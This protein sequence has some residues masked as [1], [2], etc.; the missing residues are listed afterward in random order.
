LKTFAQLRSTP[1]NGDVLSDSGWRPLAG[2][3]P[4][5]CCAGKVGFGNRVALDL[6][7]DS[8]LYTR[9]VSALR[10]S[11]LAGRTGVGPDTIRYYEKEG[12]IPEP[13][14]SA[15]GYREYDESVVERME[16]IR[17]AQAAGLRLADI[18]ILLEIKDRGQCPC[19]HTKTIID[20]RLKEISAEMTRLRQLKKRL[21]QLVQDDAACSSPD[22]W[23]CEERFI[24]AGKEARK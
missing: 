12:L 4:L 11:D 1:A 23:P 19:G 15:S 7:V 22:Y 9:A 8:R 24:Q 18:R 16:L 2:I 5:N 13:P 17:G 3:E 6:G 21:E 10:V 14:R 20:Q